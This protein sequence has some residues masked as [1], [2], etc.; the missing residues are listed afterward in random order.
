VPA[1]SQVPLPAASAQPRGRGILSGRFIPGIVLGVVVGVVLVFLLQRRLGASPDEEFKAISDGKKAQVGQFLAS[2]GSKLNSYK[3]TFTEETD[4]D[5]RIE[6]PFVGTIEF[7]YTVTKPEGQG[8]SQ[9]LHT[10]SAE[11]RYNKKDGKWVVSQQCF[12]K[13]GGGFLEPKELLVNFSDVK[14]VFDK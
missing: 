14:A 10:A 6:S 11:Y 1:S 13:Q 3:A 7:A 4:V 9:L 8:Q 2:K 5:K 12:L